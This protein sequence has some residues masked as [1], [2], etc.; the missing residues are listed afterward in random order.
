MFSL[1][2]GMQS[3]VQGL[4]GA[5]WFRLS[6]SVSE[7]TNVWAGLVILPQ[8]IAILMLSSAGIQIAM[9]KL[10][11]GRRV[12]GLMIDTQII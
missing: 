10:R 5:G 9:Y 4:G 7:K 11:R 1:G 8:A 6:A 2:F 3:A 12:S